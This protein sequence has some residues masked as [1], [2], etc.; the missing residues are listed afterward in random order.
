M[1]TGNRGR[2]Y[3]E[4]WQKSRRLGEN[5]KV[6]TEEGKYKIQRGSRDRRGGMNGC[7]TG[8]EGRRARAMVISIS[9]HFQKP[10]LPSYQGI[11]C[12]AP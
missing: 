8:K 10:V 1:K 3:S 7:K 11:M 5:P 2:R 12:T 4:V 9:L 6:N